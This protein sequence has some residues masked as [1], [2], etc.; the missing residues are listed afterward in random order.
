ML[1]LIESFITF[2]IR[3]VV[4]TFEVLELTAESL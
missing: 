3:V 2:S 4:N 1:L